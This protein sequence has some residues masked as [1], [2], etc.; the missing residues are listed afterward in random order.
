[1]DFVQLLSDT[2]SIV[3]LCTGAVAL[4]YLAVSYGLVFL[5][6]AR[7]RQRQVQESDGD[8]PSVS[9][10]IVVQN[11]ADKIRSHIANLLEQDYPDFEIIIVDYMS[12]DD[13]DYVLQICTAQYANL[14]LVRIRDD[15][16]FFHG[17]K[18]PLSLGIKSAKNDIIVLT[19]MN[20]EVP[21]LG[22][23][24]AMVNSYRFGDTQIVLGYTRVDAKKNLLGHL[25]QYDNFVFNCQYLS[26]AS[27]RHPYTGNGCNLS[28]RRDFFFDKGGFIRHY[29]EPEGADDLF[30]NRNGDRNNTDIELSPDAMVVVD[31]FD[32]M[33][34]WQYCRRRRLS[35]RCYYSFL[36]RL[37]IVMRPLTLLIFYAACVLMFFQP[38]IPWMVPVALLLLKMVWQIICVA[39]P[40]KRFQLKGYHW[41]SPL[42]ELYFVFNNAISVM[43]AF[44]RKRCNP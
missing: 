1:M 44:H 33:S 28:Y 34:V 9:V 7:I 43:L 36:Q 27:F 6:V 31:A 3:L 37:R 2:Y 18:Y 12:Q 8:L 4:I 41:F 38:A 5:R 40:L 39:Q 42:L 23:L 17:K 15:V 19:E 29:L 22:W 11:D 14:K 21:S 13:T 16:N 24:R 26:A 30:V 20:C 35:T 25:Q 32:S 10:V